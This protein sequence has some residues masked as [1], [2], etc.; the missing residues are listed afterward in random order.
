MLLKLLKIWV[1]LLVLWTV[2]NV[3]AEDIIVFTEPNEVYNTIQELY[4][5]EELNVLNEHKTS[6]LNNI[7]NSQKLLNENC[8]SKVK[9]LEDVINNINEFK[10]EQDKVIKDLQELLKTQK[11]GY[12]KVI[13][14]SKPSFFDKVLNG[15]SY[16]GIGILIG[17]LI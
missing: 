7:I 14:D 11:E 12:E 3:N 6:E 15:L 9:E 16:L 13:Q 5:C 1:I 2:N 10:L 4:K 17:I 8:D